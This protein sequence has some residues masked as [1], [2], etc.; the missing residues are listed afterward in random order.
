MSTFTII[1]IILCAL[2][3]I[4]DL[5]REDWGWAF[6]WVILLSLNISGGIRER[7]EKRENESHGKDITET[8][9]LHDIKGY[10]VD[11]TT[12]INGNDTTKTYVLTYWR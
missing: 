6:V 9:V 1:I 3:L 8:V 11:S 7:N 10:C 4:I 5:I 12:I 2:F